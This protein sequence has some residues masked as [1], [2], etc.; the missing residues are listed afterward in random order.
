MQTHANHDAEFF[1]CDLCARTLHQILH[2]DLDIHYS[3]KLPKSQ[4]LV[5]FGVYI[6]IYT[7]FVC[8]RVRVFL[9]LELNF[10]MSSNGEM[11]GN[12]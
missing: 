3:L 10:E 4:E 7:Y 5:K 8:V 12:G 2:L 11:K 6:Y 1:S 9:I